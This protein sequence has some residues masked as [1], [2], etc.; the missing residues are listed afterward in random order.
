MSHLAT[1]P[2]LM[3]KQGRIAEAAFPKLPGLAETCAPPGRLFAGQPCEQMTWFML[4]HFSSELILKCH[5]NRCVTGRPFQHS[6]HGIPS[7]QATNPNN[8]GRLLGFLPFD[9]ILIL[10]GTNGI[11]QIRCAN[12]W[13]VLSR[14]GLARSIQRFRILA[15]H[16]D[17]DEVQLLMV[18]LAL[19]VQDVCATMLG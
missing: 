9:L 3:L 19:V 13:S 15:L 2:S 10:A 16:D 4:I 7:P 12:S 14:T 8:S 17:H 11:N 6:P 5:L 18:G 1:A